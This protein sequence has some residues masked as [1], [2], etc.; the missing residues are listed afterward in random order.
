MRSHEILRVAA[1]RVGVKSL[2]SQLRLSPALIYKWCQEADP[3]DP[4]AS[5]ARNPLDRLSDIVSVTGD[6][7]P[8]QWL[9]HEAG[10]F[11]VP[12]PTGPAATPAEQLLRATQR[13]VHEFS[14]LLT[15]VSESMADDSQITPDESDRIRAQWEALK[16]VCEG[17]VIACESGQFMDR[18]NTEA[19]S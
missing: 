8:V 17:F 7:G 12:N 2:A 19:P 4:D 9:C 16:S 6:H 11:F 5:G 15:A 13:M 3:K 1:D 14:E 18:S 10:G